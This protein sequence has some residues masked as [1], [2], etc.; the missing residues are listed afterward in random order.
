MGPLLFH[1]RF[2]QQEEIDGSVHRHDERKE[3]DKRKSAFFK[4]L[5]IRI[6][7]VDREKIDPERPK[8][9]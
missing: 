4:T 5:G 6:I 9:K 3:R 1:S 2:L 8:K 7:R